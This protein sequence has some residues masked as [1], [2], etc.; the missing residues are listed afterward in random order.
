M[1]CWG[2]ERVGFCRWLW[3]CLPMRLDLCLLTRGLADS[4]TKAK[5]L[6]TDGFVS[7]NGQVRTKPAFEV[8]EDN[9]VTV[10]ESVWDRYVGRGGLKLEAALDT[11]GVSPQ[12][13]VCADIG[14]SSGGFTD[15]LLQRGAKLVYAVDAGSAQLHPKLAADERVVSMENR[16]ARYLSPDDFPCVPTLAVMD[17]SFI[18]QTLIL[19]AIAEI[20]AEEGDLITLV[21]PQFEVG[22]EGIG[23]GGIVKDAQKRKQALQKVKEC[24]GTLGFSV[25]GERESPLRGGDGNTEYLVWFRKI[26]TGKM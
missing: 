24:A 10:R 3:G 6:I 18:S 4:R 25:K 5:T 14:A 13:K 7:V 9:T 20:L 21:K 8:D 19:P 15:C 26:G 22:K 11:F 12:D 16:N 1:L 17:V 23:K 2:L